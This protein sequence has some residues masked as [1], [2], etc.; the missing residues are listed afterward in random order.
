[1]ANLKV[2]APYIDYIETHIRE[3]PIQIKTNLGFKTETELK[4]IWVLQPRQNE[5]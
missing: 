1:M 4:I 5:K 3:T 2:S